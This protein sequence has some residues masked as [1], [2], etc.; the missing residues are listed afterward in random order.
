MLQHLVQTGEGK[1]DLGLGATHPHRP[2]SGCC[3]AQSLKQGR[4]PNTW[5]AN[6]R[7]GSAATLHGACQQVLEENQLPVTTTERPR[8]WQ[9]VRGVTGLGLHHLSIWTSLGLSIAR[10]ARGRSSRSGGPVPA[11][12]LPLSLLA[13]LQHSSCSFDSRSIMHLGLAQSA[14]FTP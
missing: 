14:G 13:C 9:R 3:V 4:L 6:H 10:I 11:S 5:L 1:C 2:Y 7:G 12:L 8:C